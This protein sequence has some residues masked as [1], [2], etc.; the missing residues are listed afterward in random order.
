LLAEGYNVSGIDVSK[1]FYEQA[2]VIDHGLPD[3]RNIKGTGHVIAVVNAPY[4]PYV[5]SL[6]G[7]AFVAGKYVTAYWAWELPKVPASWQ[8]GFAVTHDI[9][10]PSSFV[11]Q[12]LRDAD[13]ASIVRVAAHPVMLDCP[14][15]KP[16]DTI[17]ARPDRPFTVISILSVGSGLARKN[18]TALIRAFKLAF[19]NRKDCRLRLLVSNAEHY[20]PA[21]PA[22]EREAT[23]AE[24]IEI[25]WQSMSRAAL[26]RWWGEADC[27]ASLHRSEGFGLPLAE[28]MCM[29]LPVIATGWSGNMDFMTPENAFPVRYSLVD[30]VDAQDKYLDGSSHWAE[31][32]VEHAAELLRDLERDREHAQAIGRKAAISCRKSLVSPVFCEALT[33]ASVAQP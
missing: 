30:V 21:R 9:A 31:P 23:D 8:R 29:G 5:L 19:G 33:G 28:A 12:A 25:T 17:Q 26:W 13:A 20:A 14:P 1:S 18:P 24:N 16:I 15:L 2:G 27:Y 32:D 3:G 22:I 4:L 6:L 10:V 7:R 11:A